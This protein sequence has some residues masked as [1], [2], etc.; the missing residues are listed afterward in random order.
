M[1]KS[2]L[3]NALMVLLCVLAGCADGNDASKFETIEANFRNVPEDSPLGVYWYWISDNLSKEGIIKDLHSMKEVGINCAY[4]GNIGLSEGDIDNSNNGKRDE[5]YGDV[6]MFSEEWWRIMHTALKTAGEL[7]VEI[8]LFN[9]PG[10]SQSGGPWIE[11]E[12][13]MRYVDAVEY[14]QGVAGVWLPRVGDLE[15]KTN[16]DVRVL[17]YP[18]IKLEHN[19]KGQMKHVDD[20]TITFSFDEPQMVRSLAIQIAQEKGVMLNRDMW[21][22]ATLWVKEDGKYKELFSF[23]ARRT[24][25]FI[26]CGFTPNTPMTMSLPSMIAKD[27]KLTFR[28]PVAKYVHDVSLSAAPCVEEWPDKT[29][30]QMCQLFQP[31]W[32]HYM[33][34]EQPVVDNQDVIVA[35][36]NVLDITAALQ[37]DGTVAWN[38]PEG[39]WL[40]KRMLMCTTGVK[41]QPSTPESTGL[42][43]D[44]MSRK[45]VS[46][47]FDSYLGEVLRR[48]PAE[49]RRTLK[50]VVQDSYETG[51]QNWTDD[52]EKDFEDHYGYDPIPFLPA[53]QGVVV[54]SADESDRFLWDLRRLVADKI[55]YDY[56]GGF[57]ELSHEHGMTTWL[58]NY[59][60]WGFPSEFL[61]YGGQSDEIAGEFW[62]GSG[63]AYVKECR[64]ASSC[65]HI[66]GKDR[67]WVE[68]FTN[69]KLPFA[70]SPYHMKQ[71]GDY[72]Y[73]HGV[74]ASILHVYIHQAY[75]DKYPGINAWFSTEFN[76]HNTWFSQMDVFGDYLKRSGDLLQQG[77]YVA[78]VAYYIGEDA[79]KMTGVLEPMLPKGHQYDYINAEI[80]LTQASVKDGKLVL[81][82][83]MEYELLVLPPQDTMRP[84]VLVKLYE[85]MQEGLVVLGPEPK[86]SPSMENYPVCDQEVQVL[87][88]RIWGAIPQG[89]KSASIGEGKIYRDASIK[90]IFDERNILPDFKTDKLLHIHRAVGNG[91]VY[92]VSN[93]DKVKRSERVAFRVTGML[94]ELW[95]PVT[96]DIRMLLEY[97][98]EGGMTYLTLSLDEIESA[99]VVFRTPTDQLQGTGENFPM[100]RTLQVVD[101][102]WEV[103]FEGLKAPADM[104]LA[105]LV[106]WTKS[107]DERLKYFS[108][109]ATYTTKIHLSN[110]SASDE[111]IYLDFGR[112]GE[113]GKVRIN[114]KDAGGVWC[115]PYRLWVN[116]LL[117]EG[118]NTIEIEVVNNWINRLIGDQSL[119]EGERVTWTLVEV[120]DMEKAILQSAGLLGPVRFLK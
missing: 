33:W 28:R 25:Y 44:K 34:R 27:F 36:E 31:P 107:D 72:Y 9:C 65:A 11:E 32:G 58:E 8:G 100:L 94:P 38:A 55:A 7:G 37:E 115:P 30:A 46:H 56:V 87:A 2:V 1:N 41:N 57:R 105:E 60:H 80:L 39:E 43:V 99:F 86:R 50:F 75:T 112:V 81:K 104:H 12:Q 45:H 64:A 73:T 26:N 6:S 14:V 79:P 10:W 67:V 21:S 68:S 49:D 113:M 89:E 97:T 66:Y 3:K 63:S 85:L 4:I 59:G 70:Q 109:T 61:M 101:T 111:P 71:T 98:Q 18:K 62:Q 23:D 88:K 51:G 77:Q 103:A 52:F 108:G 5:T 20:R 120:R 17:A 84:E 119:P 102:P 40:V 90:A 116:N 78:D 48:I 42:E 47:H 69:G 110:L 13:S 118:E 19:E 15:A 96:G 117:V 54:G 53:L 74:N 82:S 22:L 95:N 92:Y 76:D 83:G 16:Q 24:R 91:H 106:D 35:T 93:N 29:F 114:G